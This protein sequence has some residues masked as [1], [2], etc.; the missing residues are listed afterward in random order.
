MDNFLYFLYLLYLYYFLYDFIY[1]YNFWHLDY[2]LDYLLHYFFDLNYLRSN[3]KYLKYVIHIDYIH[4]LSSYHT[5]HTLINLQNSSSF[6]SDLLKFLE[7][8]FDEYS[9]MEFDFSLFFIAM[10]IDVIYSH[11]LRHKFYDL[12]Q[13]LDFVSLNHINYLLL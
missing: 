10:C 2:S 11:Y 13:F 8:S 1:S 5:N 6:N 12:N 3:S 9:Q 4:Y 7:Q